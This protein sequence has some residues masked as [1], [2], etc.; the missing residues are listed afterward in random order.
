MT[1]TLTSRR[2]VLRGAG[3]LACAAVIPSLI[4][5]VAFA[6]PDA[7]RLMR[8]NIDELTQ[9]EL[10]TYEHAV[11]LLS[12]GAASP[13][14]HPLAHPA[15]RQAA[16][17]SPANGT[18]WDRHHLEA[19]EAQLRATDPARTAEVSV[20]YWNFT[21]PASGRAYPLAFERAGSPLFVGHQSAPRLDA[22][23]WSYH[24]YIATV[25][26]QWAQDHTPL[27][28]GVAVHLWIGPNTVEIRT[29]RNITA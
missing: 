21:R 7:A 14:F 1:T 17:A 8:K 19:I 23:F 12:E 3:A 22:V 9:G 18:P 13:S 25:W 5:G 4:S 20:P 11:R 15:L 26:A 16:S 2:R 10:E 6:C 27:E 28:P 24:A 29:R